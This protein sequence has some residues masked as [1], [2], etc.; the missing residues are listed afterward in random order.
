MDLK[1]RVRKMAKKIVQ[2]P[3]RVDET[4]RNEYKIYAIQHGLTLNQLLLECVREGFQAVKKR[5]SVTE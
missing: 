3:I 2:M 4:E 5:E 1:F